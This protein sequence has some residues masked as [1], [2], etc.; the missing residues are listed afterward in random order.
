MQS[1]SRS[2]IILVF[3]ISVL[4]C[5]IEGQRIDHDALWAVPRA[6][7]AQLVIEVG[8]YLKLLRTGKVDQL[9]KMYDVSFKNSSVCTRR[10]K[11]TLRTGTGDSVSGSPFNGS[12]LVPYWWVLP[13]RDVPGQYLITINEYKTGETHRYSIGE[14]DLIAFKRGSTW[15]FSTLKP[16]GRLIL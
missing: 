13:D 5:E 3:T 11:H 9:C 14:Y 2:I 8:K 12:E 6:N 10:L 1:H 7:R 15:K 16:R 4:C